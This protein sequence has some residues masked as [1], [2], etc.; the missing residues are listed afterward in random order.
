M[1]VTVT[2]D[3]NSATGQPSTDLHDLRLLLT[4]AGLKLDKGVVDNVTPNADGA[5]ATWT[6]KELKA[7]KTAYVTLKGDTPTSGDANF[8]VK[9]IDAT[10]TPIDRTI[11]LLPA[12]GALTLDPPRGGRLRSFTKRTFHGTFASATCDREA[13]GRV[14]LTGEYPTGRRRPYKIK[15]KQTPEPATLVNPKSVV[16]GPCPF[17][18]SVKFKQMRDYRRRTFQFWAH[19]VKTGER[20][21]KA[22]VKVASD[23]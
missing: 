17:K 3:S 1:R 7:G 22:K 9:G 11:R 8:A 10:T 13:E 14:R 16:R 15:R 12:T 20:S 6:I 21:D 18:A 2:N 19:S 23:A 4:F 5:T